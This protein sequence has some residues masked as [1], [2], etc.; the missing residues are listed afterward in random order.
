MFFIATCV[1]GI[2]DYHGKTDVLLIGM[3]LVFIVL[4]TVQI[5]KGLRLNKEL[6]LNSEFFEVTDRATQR[7]YAYK[8][9]VALDSD[10][11]GVNFTLCLNDGYTFL[12]DYDLRLEEESLPYEYLELYR[13]HG[14]WNRYQSLRFLKDIFQ[15]KT[16]LPIAG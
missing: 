9:I 11:M 1:W 16:G 8:D 6:V 5:G 13:S 10:M 15:M 3:S 4:A 7:S 14:E 2:E 12:I